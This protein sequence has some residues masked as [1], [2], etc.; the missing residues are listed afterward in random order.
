MP[1]RKTTWSSGIQPGSP[2][3]SGLCV[4]NRLAQKALC[5][6]LWA[7]GANQRVAEVGEF[8]LFG[9]FLL[10]F[11]CFDQNTL[12]CLKCTPERLWASGA[13]QR[14]T[15]VGDFKHFG[16]F[17]LIFDPQLSPAQNLHRGPEPSPWFSLGLLFCLKCLP[18][19]PWTSGEAE[20][21]PGG[22]ELKHFGPGRAAGEHRGRTGDLQA[23]PGDD[24]GAPGTSGQHRGALRTPTHPG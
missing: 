10:I 1:A 14:G 11:T 19:R 4:K 12:F 8:K 21:A 2:G 20:G 5:E 6:R 7:P 18:E 23:A 9:A 3:L 16:A 15:E 22:R 24:R 13:A 17:S